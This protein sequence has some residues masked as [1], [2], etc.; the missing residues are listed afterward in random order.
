MKLEV[1]LL[2]QNFGFG[3]FFISCANTGISQFLYINH[4]ITFKY[5]QKKYIYIYTPTYSYQIYLYLIMPFLNIQVPKIPLQNYTVPH[6]THFHSQIS[7]AGSW[8]WVPW[9]SLQHIPI[10]GGIQGSHIQP[11]TNMKWKHKWANTHVS[12][13]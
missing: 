13:L 10:T 7:H 8:P 9:S 6:S 1:S 12:K 3:H 4:P 11:P 2:Y 5:P